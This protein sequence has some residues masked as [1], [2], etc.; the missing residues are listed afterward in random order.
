MMR[1]QVFPVVMQRHLSEAAHLHDLMHYPGRRVA[2]SASW[3]APAPP[4]PCSAGS[5]QCKLVHMQ[6]ELPRCASL[7][8][9]Q[10]SNTHSG[11]IST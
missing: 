7:F 2:S 3:T 9:L 5:F 6:S 10:L 4:A 1:N 11:V 8:T